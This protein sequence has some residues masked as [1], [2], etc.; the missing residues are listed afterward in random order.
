MRY[1]LLAALLSIAAGAAGAQDAD[2]G[3]DAFA[4]HC[5]VCHGETA[6]GDGPMVPVLTVAPSDL[7]SLAAGNDGVFPTAR[8]VRRIDGR[9]EVMAHGG[10]MPLFGDILGG[11]S[12][13]IDAPDGS[14]VFTTEEIVDITA[15][16]QAI[17][18][19]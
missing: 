7:T 9:E 15:W 2:R 13:V 3:A 18:V 8:V 10:P 16:L 11:A 1:M 14:P 6:M 17:Q 5:A 12:G 19:E 4:D